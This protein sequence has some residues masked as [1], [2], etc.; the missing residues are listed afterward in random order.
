MKTVDANEMKSYRGLSYAN[1]TNFL[2]G[3]AYNEAMADWKKSGR[4]DD[5]L[6]AILNVVDNRGGG[7]PDNYV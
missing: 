2:G 7:D 4:N 5:C 6:I 3:I 1:M